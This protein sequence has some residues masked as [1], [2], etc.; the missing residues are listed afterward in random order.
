M[1]AVSKEDVKTGVGMSNGKAPEKEKREP[2]GLKK[3]PVSLVDKSLQ[4]KRVGIG[5]IE[6]SAAF[7]FLNDENDVVHVQK[8]PFDP[9]AL[10]TSQSRSFN[11]ED[12]IQ[13]Q[14]KEFQKQLDEAN[15]RK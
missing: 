13:A 4:P 15:R 14:K 10:K 6:L 12:W 9:N 11:L 3:E 2:A 8:V 1:S 7:V 5:Q